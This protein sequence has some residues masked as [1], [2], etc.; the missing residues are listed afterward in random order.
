MPRAKRRKTDAAT[1]PTAEDASSSNNT[2]RNVRGRRGGLQDFPKMPLD[3][4]LEVRSCIVYEITDIEVECPCRSFP[5]S[6]RWTCST[7]LARIRPSGNFLWI[8]SRPLTGGLPEIPCDISEPAF[9][10]LLFNPHCHVRVL[11]ELCIC[12]VTDITHRRPA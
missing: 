8:K 12:G 2:R 4:S 1:T 10:N 5:V 7:S 3:I 6:F 11:R 9:A